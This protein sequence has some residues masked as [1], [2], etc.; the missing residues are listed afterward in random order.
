[1]PLAQHLTIG[2]LSHNPGW[3]ILL[4]QIGAIWE[5]IPAAAQITPARYSVVI[6]AHGAAINAALSQQLVAYVQEGGSLL[7]EGRK[8]SNSIPRAGQMKRERLGSGL[9]TRFPF[10]NGHILSLGMGVGRQIT[11]TRAK[12]QLF[13]APSAI[14]P[15]EIVARQNKGKLRMLVHQLLSNLHSLHDLPFLTRWRFPNN[16]PTIFCYRIDSDHGTQPQIEQLHHLSQAYQLPLTWFL[17]TEAHQGWLGRFAQFE[18]DELGLH[19]HRHRTF[20]SYGENAENIRYALELLRQHGIAPRGFAAPNGFW[21]P[22]LAEAIARCQFL[23]SSEFSLGYDDLP[24]F[25][26]L[27]WL[28]RFGTL[29][30][31][32]HPVSPGNFRRVGATTAQMIEHYETML[33]IKLRAAEPVIFYHHPTHEQWGVTE[34]IFASVRHHNIP[35]MTMSQYAEWWTRRSKASVRAT[36]QNGVLTVATQSTDDGGDAPDD[37]QISIEHRG[38]KGALIPANATVRL[39]DIQWESEV[40]PHPARQSVPNFNFKMLFHSVED[41]LTRLRQ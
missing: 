38:Q 31:P 19:C 13:A 25:P 34:A 40:Y 37:L 2:L 20:K 39:D 17:H 26:W 4:E 35:A 18:G 23:Y 36:I 16:A 10:R 41:F 1:M 15:S 3:E 22:G 27:G 12:R 8:L 7:E 14:L 32:I 30:V 5:V 29:Q 6:I 9:L 33:Q 21:N 28:G 11:D 24:F